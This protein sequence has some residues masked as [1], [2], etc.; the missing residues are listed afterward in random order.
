MVIDIIQQA[1]KGP[2]KKFIYISFQNILNNHYDTVFDII[3]HF[4][5]IRLKDV[6]EFKVF[7]IKEMPQDLDKITFST[8]YKKAVDKFYDMLSENSSDTSDKFCDLLD[9]LPHEKKSAIFLLKLKLRCRKMIGGDITDL[10]DDDAIEKSKKK[11]MITRNM[12]RILHALY[13]ST[14]NVF[15]IVSDN[16]LKSTFKIKVPLE[17]GKTNKFWDAQTG[18]LHGQTTDDKY[19]EAVRPFADK[20]SANIIKYFLEVNE[21]ILKTEG[22]KQLINVFSP[23]N[24]GAYINEIGM[25]VAVD[26]FVPFETLKLTSEVIQFLAAQT[27]E[28]SYKS[29]IINKQEEKK[30]RKELDVYKNNLELLQKEIEELLCLIKHKNPDVK[31]DDILAHEMKR[32]GLKM[33]FECPHKGGKNEIFDQLQVMKNTIDN[34]KTNETLMQQ[35]LYYIVV[36]SNN[37]KNIISKIDSTNGASLP[38]L[39]IKAIEIQSDYRSLKSQFGQFR[40]V[41]NSD[42]NLKN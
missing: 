36:I 27:K 38:E 15:I 28:V 40:V 24:I 8:K 42:P 11:G 12:R 3:H 30:I 41:I 22:F 33:K 16:I 37:I 10:D 19:M 23:E 26:T 13:A 2:E 35:E 18:G 21:S 9:T 32:E 5:D 25:S 6:K 4:K 29:D 39:T 20:L 17:T 34:K 1:L 14:M 31:I 7:Q